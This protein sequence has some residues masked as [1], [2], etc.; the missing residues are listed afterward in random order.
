MGFSKYPNSLDDSTSLPPSLDLITPVKAEVVNRLRDAILAIEVELGINPSSVFGTV[1]ARMGDLDSRFSDIESG[2]GGDLTALQNNIDANTV[3]ID[4]NIVLIDANTLLITNHILDVSN[5]HSVTAAQAGAP[6]K[7]S[8]STD[9]AIMR[10]DGVLGQMQNSA[11]GP[12][13]T[14]AGDFRMLERTGDPSNIAD[15]GFLYTKDDGGVTQLFYEDSDG[16]VTQVTGGAT[17]VTGTGIDDRLARWNGTSAIQSSAVILR[18]TGALVIANTNVLA[19]RNAADSADITTVQVSAGNNITFGSTASPAGVFV[20]AGSSQTISFRPNSA[21]VTYAMSGSLFIIPVDLSIGATPALTG[22]VRVESNTAIMSRNAA[23][24]VDITLIKADGNN[25]IRIGQGGI[26]GIQFDA[27][28]VLNVGSSVFNFLTSVANPI[29]RHTNETT[30]ATGGL[31]TIHSQ[32]VTATSG[33]AQT[34][35]RLLIHA[36]DCTNGTTNTGGDLDIR[37]GSGLTADGVLA[38]QDGGAINRVTI[39]A[40]GQITLDA[41]SDL[42]MHIGGALTFRILGDNV[43]NYTSTLQFAATVSSPVFI[44]ATDSTD[45]GGGGVTGDLFMFHSQ[46]TSGTGTANVGGAMLIRAGDSTNGSSTN[47]GGDLTLRPG[48]GATANGAFQLQDG[49]GTDRAT[50]SSNGA[51]FILDLASGG[52][53]SVNIGGS[54]YFSISTGFVTLFNS[55]DLRW[56]FASANPMIYHEDEASAGISGD[57]FTIHAQNTTGTG[58]KAGG[59]LTIHA[60]DNSGV[61]TDAT[62]GDLTLRGG[63]VTGGATSNTGGDVIVIAGSA[64]GGFTSI[65]GDV[66]LRLGTLQEGTGAIRIQEGDTTDIRTFTPTLIETHVDTVQWDFAVGDITFRHETDT[67]NDATGASFIFNAQD[68]TGAGTATTGGS[69]TIRAGDATGA[70]T[71]GDGGDLTIR[72]GDSTGATTN[73]GGDLI[74]RPGDG[75]DTRGTLSLRDGDGTQRIAIEPARDVVFNG[76][77]NVTIQTLDTPRFNISSTIVQISVSTLQFEDTVSIPVIK[78][79]TDSND[80]ATGDLFTINA[81]DVSGGGTTITGGAMLIRAGDASG[82]ATS[83]I[84]GALTL[85]P[86]SGT[87]TNGVLEIQN[88]GGTKV[89]EV[90]STG[91]GFF[92]TAP[93]AKVSDYTRNAAVVTDKTLLASGSATTINNNNVLAAIIADL[94]AYGLFGGT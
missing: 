69:L 58:D 62:G 9:E 32:N 28:G 10:Y 71:T 18:D 83:D 35:G 63:D 92:A 64:T 65:P 24:S 46:D 50:L 54:V 33:G 80:N 31:L 51:L 90:N 7:L 75:A 48:S 30:A 79:N 25:T 16:G 88:G 27:T 15:N 11:V 38:L 86:G 4:A 73:N 70:P 26:G 39:S 78:Q 53:N 17:A 1:D 52:V 34:G 36:G 23:D 84:G 37:P 6:N 55:A 5:P 87:T 91:I 42:Q 76:N 61:A 19:G 81:Q 2:I 77:A 72:A 47:T 59:S 20:D 66:I 94:Q 57:L 85:R 29:I 14:D 21:G 8:S 41:A 22:A 89:I 44:Q 49:D 12:F 13:V 43:T 68:V 45:G 82:A 60:G 93:V 56:Q 67:A 74:L 40:A 3:L